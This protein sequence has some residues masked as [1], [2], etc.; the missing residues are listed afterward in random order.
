MKKISLLQSVV[1]AAVFAVL[2]FMKTNRSKIIFTLLAFGVWLPALTSQAALTVTNIAT[3]CD[4]NH[5]LF[6]K[7]DGS[8]WGMGDNSSGE[9]GDGFVD[10]YPH[11]GTARTEQIFPPPQ[12]ILTSSVISKTNLQVN[13]TTLFGGTFY[14]RAST[15]LA[16]PLS[17]WQPLRTN[18][19]T[20]RGTNNFSVT[21]T[22]AV[23]SS[24]QQFYILQSQ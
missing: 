22:N 10:V 5:T 11:F 15:N 1:G 19:V 13:A 4:L 8:L 12:P 3:G 14:L 23:N 2:H 9:L 20:A 7:S 6:L 16:V 18:S 21:L 17:Q 24:S